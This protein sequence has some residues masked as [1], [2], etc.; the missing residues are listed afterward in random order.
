MMLIRLPLDKNIVS[1]LKS[2]DVVELTGDIY[3]ARDAAH[4][5]LTECISRGEDLPFDINNQIVFYTGPCPAKPGKIIGPLSPTTSLRMDPYVEAL[6]KKGMSAMIGKGDRS[7]YI[8]SLC[9]KYR[10]VYLLGIGGAA[11]LISSRV[12]AYETVCYEDLG[13][14]SVKRLTFEKLKVIVGIDANGGV[15]Q[16]TEI[17]KYRR[18]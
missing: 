12:T 17:K 18:T 10:A 4:K 7:D 13:T 1:Q 3:T 9:K 2:G 16:D 11:A 8:P 6:L 14:E 15:L 5:R